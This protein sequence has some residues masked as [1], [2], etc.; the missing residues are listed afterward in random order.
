[1]SSIPRGDSDRQPPNEPTYT[2]GSL[3]SGI[4][5]IDLAFAAVGFDVRWQVEIDPY[6]QKVLRKHAPNYWPNAKLHEDVKHVGREQLEAVD[7]MFGGFPCQDISVAGK[8]AGLAE[9]TR[10]GLWF[11]FLRIIGELRPRIVVLENVANINVLGGTTVIGSLTEIG[12][13]ALWFPLRASDAGAPHRRERWFCVAYRDGA[14]VEGRSQAGNA[15]GK[16]TQADQHARRRDQALG[17][18]ER[19][20]QHR[21][22]R[23][24]TEPQFANRRQRLARATQSRLGGDFAGLSAWLDGHRWPAGLGHEQ[25]DYEPPRVVTGAKNRTAR[26]KALGNSVVPQV[27]LPIAQAVREYLD[28]QAREGGAE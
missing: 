8:R 17:N 22:A 27:V 20:R 12:Y 14:R 3:F 23:R 13:D 4:G 21:I 25:H 28:A 15:G 9:G 26:I 6:C 5:G 18:T 11:E 10:S 16:G 24:R 2:V 7:V 1:M 19:S